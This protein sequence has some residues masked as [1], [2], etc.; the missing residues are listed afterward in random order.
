M[1]LRS[2][3]AT[4]PFPALMTGR[5]AEL[6]AL[7]RQFDASER[8]TPAALQ[9]AQLAQLGQ[10]VA[11]AAGVAFHAA[12]LRAAGIDPAAPLS[13]EAWQRLPVMGRADLPRCAAE[14]PPTHGAVSEAASAGT[15]AAPVRVRKTALDGLLWQA[16]LVREERWHRGR[17]EATMLRLTAVPG[18]LPAALAAAARGPDGLVLPDAGPPV[19]ELWHTGRLVLADAD[20]TPDS[21]RALIARHRP[22]YLHTTPAL[23]RT[24][25]PH[26]HG[27]PPLD[28]VWTTGAVVDD[29]LRAACRATLGAPIVASYSAAETGYLA[30]QCPL[31][32]HHHVLSETCLLELLDEAGQPAAAGRVVVTPLHNFAMPLLR[33]D[34]GDRA[35]FGPPC[36]CG[37]TL[38]VLTRIGRGPPA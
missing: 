37:R 35:A 10:L 17:P 11:H 5:A 36:A 26:L 23:L 20:R 33:Y 31:H 14:P 3:L 21:V 22:A 28:G 24:L 7:Q 13:W 1:R 38:Q 6:M 29:G 16:A 25:L 8:W 27:L 15:T 18:H 32:P 12:R 9:A 19:S 2:A 4:M 34:L 30:L